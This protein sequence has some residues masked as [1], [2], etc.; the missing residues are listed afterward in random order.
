MR[1][2]QRLP[3]LKIS[4]KRS[5]VKTTQEIGASR[6]KLK[7]KKMMSMSIILKRLL[8]IKRKRRRS[9]KRTKDRILYPAQLV[10]SW[11]LPKTKPSA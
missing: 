5:S 11:W 9:M 7:M 3:L 4:L 1:R 6:L 10:L 8:N 2:S